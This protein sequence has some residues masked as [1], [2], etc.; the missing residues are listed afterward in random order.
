MVN[1]AKEEKRK[2][3]E[4]DIVPSL[5]FVAYDMYSY[6]NEELKR[7]S[8]PHESVLKFLST[9]FETITTIKP[10]STPE[11]TALKLSNNTPPGYTNSGVMYR[12]ADVSST[13][14]VNWIKV[15]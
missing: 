6:W 8:N 15:K 1:E 10:L 9:M 2:L 11:R 5:S 14:T 3:R 7:V 12:L 4:Y 13:K